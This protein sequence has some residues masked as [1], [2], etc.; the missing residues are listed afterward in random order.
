MELAP[1]KGEVGRQQ[2]P[3]PAVYVYIREAHRHAMPLIEGTGT[4]VISEP[5]SSMQRN[6]QRGQR[7]KMCVAEGPAQDMGLLVG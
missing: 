1:F 7:M 3:D 2:S 6:G 5:V 4:D